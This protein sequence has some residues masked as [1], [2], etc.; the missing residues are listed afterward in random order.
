M[1][2]LR[3]VARRHRL[4][5]GVILDEVQH[6]TAAVQRG[7]KSNSSTPAF[8]AG[9]YF[10][11]NWHDWMNDNSVFARMSIAS[12]HGERDFQLPDGEGHR[13]RVVEPLT[14]G[15]REALQSHPSSPAYVSD[16]DV[17]K[18]IVFYAGNILRSLMDAGFEL[19]ADS[20]PALD[21]EL[22]LRL[23]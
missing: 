2:N 21:T 7:D 14:D 4:G 20:P 11:N 16:P 8:A 3:G 10:R 23:R 22:S 9:S 19:P 15:Q 13:L 12:A 18:R 5:I 17:R 1:E 6:I